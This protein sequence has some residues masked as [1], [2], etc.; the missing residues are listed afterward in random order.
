MDDHELTTSERAALA[1]WDPVPTPPGFAD[2]VVAEQS[3]ELVED[4]AKTLLYPLK[5]RCS[6]IICIFVVALL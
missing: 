3:T 1:A 5:L 6:F 2:R 4:G